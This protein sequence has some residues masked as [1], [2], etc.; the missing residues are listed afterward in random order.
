MDSNNHII[1]EGIYCKILMM[2]SSAFPV[3][4]FLEVR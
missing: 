2:I 4:I 1:I 3:T